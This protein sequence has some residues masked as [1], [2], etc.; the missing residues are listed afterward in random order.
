MGKKY[1]YSGIF[2]PHIYNYNIN[3]TAIGLAALT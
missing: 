3:I 1:C 2:G